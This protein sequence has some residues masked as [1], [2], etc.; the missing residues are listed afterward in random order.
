MTR[1]FSLTLLFLFTTAAVAKTHRVVSPDQGLRVTV[2]LTHII[3]YEV[4][5]NGI[6]LVAP[7]QIYMECDGG[8]T[9][10]L[11]PKLKTVTE[12]WTDQYLYPV[13]PRKNKVVRDNYNEMTFHFRGKYSLTFRVYDNGIAYR[14]SGQLKDSLTV[15]SE[16]ASFNFSDNH[17]IW[18]PEEESMFS[19]QERLYKEIKFSEIGT[20]R[21]CSTAAL[22]ETSDGT[23]ILIT[24]SDLFD[25][26][27]MYLTGKKENP[28]ALVGKFAG[29]P[30][31]V[32]QENDRNV[33]VTEHADFIAKTTGNRTFPWRLLIIAASD[34]ELLE[35]DLVWQLASPNQIEDPSWIHPGKV[36]WDWWNA[37]NIYGIDFR[38]GIN[39]DTYKYYIDFAAEYGIEYIILDEGWYHLGNVLDV[40]NEIDIQAL[41]DYASEKNVGIILWVIW[42]TLYDD[43]DTALQQFEDWGVKGIKVDF[44]QRDDQWM[45][46]Y[47]TEVAEKAAEH[48]LLVDYHGAYKPAGLHRTYPNVL[49]FEGVKGLENC[50]WGDQITPDHDLT[51]PFIRMVTGPMDYTP[52]A[53]LNAGKDNFKAVWSEPMSQGTRCHQLAMYV[54]Y[55]SP[56]QMLA[57]NP[58]NYKKEPE[59]MEFLS[60]VPVVW[61][62]TRVL[63]ARIKDF[64]VMARKKDGVW[65]V[66][67]MTDWEPRVLM[68]PLDFLD[69]GNYTM[70]IWKDG[71]NADRHAADFATETLEVTV[72]SKASIGMAPG[73]GWVAIIKPK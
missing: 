46:N 38:A 43:L 51:I 64:I 34:K 4:W 59:C 39:N 63:E 20:T 56:L 69:E 49:T 73:G 70:K 50:K 6:Q 62:E 29:F 58:S 72:D 13:V 32:K 23:K 37:N 36:A 42:K 2:Y 35:A 16:K 21:F 24:E 19:H 7:S 53:M 9:F 26:P 15:S 17:K 66:A 22:V 40:V 55:E 10:G 25:Y 11:E 47:Y 52:G 57:D 18:F 71:N 5:K 61:D 48:Q 28:Y 33:K 12:N 8:L 68:L 1:L 60:R 65:Y 41:T 27:G 45:V 54:V 67:A 44:M 14:W 3:T 30:L 31:K